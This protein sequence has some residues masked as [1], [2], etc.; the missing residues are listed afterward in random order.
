MSEEANLENR[1]LAALNEMLGKFSP[2]RQSELV[3]ELSQCFMDLLTK[4]E[5]AKVKAK[6]MEEMMAGMMAEA[7]GMKDDA[8]RA[9]TDL[10]GG[11]ESLF[12]GFM[13]A[14]MASEEPEE[15]STGEKG[16]S[17][18]ISKMISEMIGS[19]DNLGEKLVKLLFPLIRIALVVLG[20]RRA[21]QVS[22]D[23]IEQ[24][25]KLAG[26]LTG[27]ETWSKLMSDVVSHINSQMQTE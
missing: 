6:A 15:E 9:L 19:V 24:V 1:V 27:Q 3:G 12:G 23:W 8:L 10:V 7:S 11:M 2:E 21:K 16:P 22:Q 5:Q 26:G 20:L 4:E 13:A 25:E 17:M 18:D 14:N